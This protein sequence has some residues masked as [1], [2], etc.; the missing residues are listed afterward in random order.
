M[1]KKKKGGSNTWSNPVNNLMGLG[2]V[3]TEVNEEGME[4]YDQKQQRT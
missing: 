1:F 2:G 4:T 3:S